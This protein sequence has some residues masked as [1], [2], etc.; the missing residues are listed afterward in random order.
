MYK[1]QGQETGDQI[2]IVK[3]YENLI[4][5]GNQVEQ[6]RFVDPEGQVES[7]SLY[8][9]SIKHQ[10]TTSDDVIYGFEGNDVIN[11]DDGNDIVHAAAGDDV[12]IGGRGND[13]LQGG[14]GSD[15]YLF[16]AGSGHDVIDNNDK[17]AS[18]VDVIEFDDSINRKQVRLLRA[19]DD[20][21]ISIDRNK[22]SIQLKGYFEGDDVSLSAVDEIRFSDGAVLTVEDIRSLSLDA[23][24]GADYIEGFS[25]DDA[26]SALAG[27]DIVY[28]GNGDDL[29]AGEQGADLIYGENGND[30]LFGNQDR[31]QLYG[32]QG[33]DVLDG[34][35]DSDRLYGSAGEDLLKG[36]DGNDYLDGGA[37]NDELLGNNGDDSIYGM[38][39][40]DLI[41]GGRGDDQLNGGFGDDLIKGDAGD[42]SYHYSL[43][44]GEDVLIDSSGYD[45]LSLSGIDIH[46]V[47]LTQQQDDLLIEF[48]GEQGEITIKDWN[49]SGDRVIDEIHLGE[50]SLVNSQ[51][52]S[53]V[54]SMSAFDTESDSGTDQFTMPET[55]EP[56]LA[57]SWQ[58][59]S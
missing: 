9:L 40:N 50:M 58:P 21:L 7:M 3:A 54:Q 10:A 38:R 35:K 27:D 24:Q 11:A 43:G 13:F 23:T 46:Q 20:L 45:V 5:S 2:T 14:S 57:A 51:I 26:I 42:D 28:A 18:S 56:V 53:L 6:V 8:A 52:D 12:I 4:A 32:G 44:D 34:G 16:S 30:M 17:Q 55:L 48:L 33:N 31:D 39:G 29:V 59:S 49:S 47:W 19:G 25:S 1:R 37:Q 15:K 36:G 41:A 22:D